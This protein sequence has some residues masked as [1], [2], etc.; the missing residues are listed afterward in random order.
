MAF[1]M[2]SVADTVTTPMDGEPIQVRVPIN[3]ISQYAECRRHHDNT[4]GRGAHTDTC[5]IHY[6]SQYAERSRHR[7]NTHGRGAHTGTC[8]D[9]L[10]QSVCRMSPTP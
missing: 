2:Q 6:I 8:T 10:Y 9:Q 7:D 3:Y 5:T 4:H 1:S